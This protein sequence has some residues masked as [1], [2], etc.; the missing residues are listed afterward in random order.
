MTSTDK[1]MDQHSKDVIQDWPTPTI[2]IALGTHIYFF[3]MLRNSGER[4]GI[5]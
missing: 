4:E 2:L 1:A 3:D 5:L